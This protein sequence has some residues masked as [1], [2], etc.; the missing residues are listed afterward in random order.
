MLFLSLVLAAQVWH[1][2]TSDYHGFV[3]HDFTV[4][5]LPALVVEPKQAAKGNPWVWRMEFFDHRPEFDLAMLGRGY[6]LAYINVGNTFG[7]PSA[8]DNLGQFYRELTGKYQFKPKAILE[9]LSRGGLYAYQ[10]AAR[11]PDKVAVLYGDAPVCDFKTWP[12]GARGGQRSDDDWK[13]LIDDYGFPDEKAAL[14]FPFNPIDNL[15]PLAKAK[16]PIIHI[17]G[18]AD[19]A[20]PMPEN[21]GIVE[22]RYKALGGTM[23]VIHKPG[24][25]HHPHGLDDPTPLVQFVQKHE[26]DTRRSP[27]APLIPAPSTESRYNLAGWQ[28]LSWLEQHRQAEQF[29]REEKAEVILLGDSITQNFGDGHRHISAGQSAAW[30]QYLAPLHAANMGIAGDRVQNVAWRIQEGALKGLDPKFVV[31]HIG[32]NNLADDKPE[33]IAKGIQ[34]V[35]GQIKKEAPRAKIILMGLFGTGGEPTTPRRMAAQQVNALIGKFADGKRV[36]FLNLESHFIKADGTL[37]YNLI[38]SDTIHPV[39]GGYELW[40]KALTEAIRKAR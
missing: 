17:V 35:L 39:A 32:T 8:C 27:A 37:D 9:G 40:G 2:Q 4:N 12:Y 16:I 7:C 10:F 5:G 1:G 20:V 30:K 13:K 23:E 11:N 21:T 29:A 34:S 3:R 28:G 19:E 38:S 33:D 22:K 24:G 14:E 15:A 25:K 36:H 26:D 18:D 6:F 31:L